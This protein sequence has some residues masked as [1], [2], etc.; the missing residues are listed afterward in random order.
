MQG[1]GAP[2]K[3]ARHLRKAEELRPGTREVELWEARKGTRTLSCVATYLATGVDVRLLEDGE[4]RRTQYGDRWAEG[5][6]PGG[7]V[8]GGGDRVGLELWWVRRARTAGPG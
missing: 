3:V 2:K 7:G 1:A 8:E 4:M 6:G 5:G